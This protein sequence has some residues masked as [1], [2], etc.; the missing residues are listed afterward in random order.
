MNYI[1]T[2][3]NTN[4]TISWTLS[5]TNTW[6]L[7]FTW[8]SFSAIPSTLS[9]SYEV[10]FCNTVN[11][12][13]KCTKKLQLNITNQTR[14]NKRTNTKLCDKL[15]DTLYK[16][17]FNRLLTIQECE[18]FKKNRTDIKKV[19]WDENIW[20][21][22]RRDIF[23]SLAKMDMTWN[24]CVNYQLKKWVKETWDQRC[25][26]IKTEF[27]WE[28]IQNILAGKWYDIVAYAPYNTGFNM[29]T[30]SWPITNSFSG[31]EDS[32]YE[33]YN[34]WTQF[35][36]DRGSDTS[37]IWANL[38]NLWFTVS[39][40]N[41][42]SLY[43]WWRY[44]KWVFLDNHDYNDYL[45]YSIPN[46][47]GLSSWSWFAIEM[48][49]RGSSLKRTD[50]TYTYTLFSNWTSGPKLSLNNSKLKIYI[51]SSSFYE[52]WITND[53]KNQLKN[54]IF[55]KVVFEYK[56]WTW[57]LSLYDDYKLIKEVSKSMFISSVSELYIWWEKTTTSPGSY[58]YQWNDI[59]DYVK[60]YKKDSSPAPAPSP[61][62]TRAPW[63]GV[64]P[65]IEVTRGA[66]GLMTFELD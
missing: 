9:W 42:K 65:I 21:E 41:S 14:Y 22:N 58:I 13:Q 29:N 61:I 32:N 38:N 15:L 62:T 46:S 11:K 54:H 66:W 56:N 28:T 8:W 64:W 7:T 25:K 36:N 20:K 50:S 3:L 4:K 10:K 35:F 18:D 37:L 49:V 59:I 55:Y 2:D 60:F 53:L 52:M 47:L 6:T 16:D 43:R 40:E 5:P 63:W 34:I 27:W 45:K 31:I 23:K 19:L 44:G 1:A 33:K 26:S 24:D 12:K 51:T 39:K 17:L 48:S 30:I 57:T